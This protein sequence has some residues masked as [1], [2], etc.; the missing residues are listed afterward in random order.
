MEVTVP[1]LGG[2][3]VRL[4]GNS[5]CERDG[6]LVVLGGMRLGLPARPSFRGSNQLCFDGANWLI[7]TYA[8]RVKFP[9]PVAKAGGGRSGEATREMSFQELLLARV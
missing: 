7:L 5:V 4:K 3:A 8:Q 6:K 9:L 2:R 1:T